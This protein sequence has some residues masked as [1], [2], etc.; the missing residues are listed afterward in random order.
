MKILLTGASSYVGAR[1]FLDLNKKYEVIGTYSNSKLS[2]KL[3]HLDVTSPEEVKQ[4]LV[5]Q[6][7]DVIIHAAANANARWC[8]ANPKKAIQLNQESTESIVTIANEISAKVILIS[9]FAVLDPTNVYGK[10][11]L[12]SEAFVK[13][14]KSGYV[15]LRPSFILGFSPNTVNDRPFNRILKNL[16]KK[17]EA[18]YDTSWKFHPTSLGHL[19]EVIEIIVEQN[20]I[21]ETIAVA[22]PELKTRY[23]VAKDILT[24]FGIAVTAIDK[25]DTSSVTNDDL[26]TLKKLHLPQYTYQEI[27]KKIINEIQHREMYT[28]I[29]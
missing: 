22:V 20:I 7:P 25:H 28:N 19:S 1:L 26:E 24:P 10:T 16:D 8:E 6:K 4:L 13:Q 3:V 2:E 9:S 23:D 14:T 29:A 27:I 12:A 15:I 11:K 17:T 5:E 18:L 21:N